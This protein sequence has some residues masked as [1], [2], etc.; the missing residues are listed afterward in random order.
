MAV[1]RFALISLLLSA[2]SAFAQGNPTG[3]IQGKVLDPDGLALPGVTVTVASPALQ[4]TRT[5]VT[6]VNGD[7]IIPFLPPGLYTITWE[8]AGFQTAT[9]ANLQVVIAE[10]QK[11]DAQLAVAGLSETVQVTGTA[12]TEVAPN[13]TVASTY[14][15]ADIERLPVGRTL[16][17]AVLLAPN[18]SDNGPGGNIM[19]AGAV[20]YENLFLINGVVVTA[21]SAIRVRCW[22]IITDVIVVYI[23]F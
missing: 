6:S 12:P 15:A 14:K 13:L 9:R 7:Y 20:S 11:V 1:A 5:V 21:R 23:W 22:R 17:A 8:L 4:G 10:T 3:G 18:V 19:I 2:A 16:N